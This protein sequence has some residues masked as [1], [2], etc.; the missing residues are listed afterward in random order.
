MQKRAPKKVK[1]SRPPRAR[2]NVYLDARTLKI[3]DDVT[4]ETPEVENRS[5][6]IRYLCRWY[7]MTSHGRGA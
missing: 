1:S 5:A 3:L 2:Q 6:A 7:D 4:S